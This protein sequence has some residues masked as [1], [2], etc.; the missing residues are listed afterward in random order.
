RRQKNSDDDTNEVHVKLSWDGSQH[1]LV[2][3]A[4]GSTLISRLKKNAPGQIQLAKGDA[5][6][7]ETVR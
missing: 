2:R 3:F 6:E 1:R 5:Q 7:R 4:R